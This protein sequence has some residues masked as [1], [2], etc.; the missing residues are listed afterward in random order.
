[1]VSLG[2]SNDS[3]DVWCGGWC[4]FAIAQE[5]LQAE[6]Q[7]KLQRMEEDRRKLMMDLEEQKARG[8]Q[9]KELEARRKA[10][11]DNQLN[12]VCG[13]GGGAFC[14][15]FVNIIGERT[16]SRGLSPPL[17][18]IS[19]VPEGECHGLGSEAGCRVSPFD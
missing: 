14:F 19:H 10:Q 8:L 13:D 16:I 11:L 2:G 7:L 5:E 3:V 9:L 1:M 6:F 12:E 4:V 15:V 18:G 17:S